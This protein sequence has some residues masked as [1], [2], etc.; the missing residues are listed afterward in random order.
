MLTILALNGSNPRG[1]AAARIN[2]T[3]WGHANAPVDV[4]VVVH[5]DRNPSNR[6]AVITVVSENYQSASTAVLDGDKAP[7]LLRR[8][9]SGL[10]EGHYQAFL[11]LQRWEGKWKIEQFKSEV[12][13]VH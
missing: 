3:P 13:E 5:V 7:F 9:I 1:E 10:R 4:E 6:A 2:L 8:K 11:E 12:L